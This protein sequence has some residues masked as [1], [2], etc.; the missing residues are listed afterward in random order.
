MS[1]EL[2]AREIFGPLG[3]VLEISAVRYSGYLVPVEARSFQSFVAGIED[4]LAA[5]LDQIENLSKISRSEASIFESLGY[6]AP[7]E[8]SLAALVMWSCG[9]AGF[10]SNDVERM[11]VAGSDIQL[12][13]LTQALIFSAPSEGVAA[14]SEVIRR[15]LLGCLRILGRSTTGDLSLALRIWSVS[16]LPAY[17]S[18]AAGASA[19]SREKV[20]AYAR[21]LMAEGFNP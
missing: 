4:E 6:G 11:V 5:I 17:L 13:R 21:C 3:G 7:H 12:S 10:S 14:N 18:P 20:R 1:R 15:I 2:V 16:I 19:D 9:V 8:I